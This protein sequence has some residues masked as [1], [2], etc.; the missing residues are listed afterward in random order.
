[1]RKLIHIF[2]AAIILWA[3]VIGAVSP[4]AAQSGSNSNQGRGQA[5]EIAPPVIYLN[6]DPGQTIKTK[7]YLRNISGGD[8][9]VTGEANDFVADGEQG[10]PKILLDNNSSSK[11]QDPYSLKNWI[12]PPNSLLLVPKEIKTMDVAITV[13]AN[14]SPGG[15]YGVIRFT[16][17]PP[18]LRGTGVSL[19]ASLGSLVLLTVSGK[20]KE[21][22]TIKEFSVNHKG[23]TGTM[24]ESAPLTFV[25]RLNNSGNVHEQPSGII[26]IKDM[27]G[28]TLAAMT[29]N[30]PPKSILPQSTRRFESALDK[31]VIGKKRLFGRYH[32]SL[33]LTYGKDK[34]VLTRDISFWVIPWKLV[35]IAIA[36]IIAAFFALRYGLR[37]Y[38][39]YIIGRSGGSNRGSRT[40][41]GG[42]RNRR[43]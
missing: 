17:T 8:L 18:S 31:T 34:K 37:R 42:R 1:M 36:A 22:L 33:K 6:A 7:I 12:H 16:G 9:I 11:E 32:A 20:I 38:N 14:A 30:Q 28:K 26:T 39:D 29:V 5:L 3:A 24:F 2:L 13:P 40:G 21:N 10:T 35:A 43:R 27:F 19:S 25:S 15:H 4:V 41:R 23:K